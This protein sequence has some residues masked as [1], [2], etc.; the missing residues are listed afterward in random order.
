MNA[1]F[2]TYPSDTPVIMRTPTIQILASKDHILIKA[3]SDP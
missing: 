1:E 3:I 2:K